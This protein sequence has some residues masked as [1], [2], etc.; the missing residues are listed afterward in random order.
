MMLIPLVHIVAQ[1]PKAKALVVSYCRTYCG[2]CQI[3]DDDDGH[4]G[5]CPYCERETCPKC[6]SPKWGCCRICSRII[7]QCLEPINVTPLGPQS[8]PF[9]GMQP[10]GIMPG[11]P[12]R[13]GGF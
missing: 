6:W 1:I 2:V 7:D 3:N 10:P 12:L 11:G 9:G 8:D 4:L 13:P 5:T